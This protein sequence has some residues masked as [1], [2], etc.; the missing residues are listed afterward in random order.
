MPI[1]LSLMPLLSACGGNDAPRSELERIGEE[2]TAAQSSGTV[3]PVILAAINDPIMVDPQLAASA[4]PDAVR[5]PSEPYAAAVPH[6][7]IARGSFLN[8]TDMSGTAPAAR[9]LSDPAARQAITLAAL[10]RTLGGPRANACADRLSYSADWANR[11]PAG[12]PLHPDAR[13]VEAG[14]VEGGGCA[15]RVASVHVARPTGTLVGWYFGRARQAGYS[16]DHLI[17]G[18]THMLAGKR[19]DD[20]AAFVLFLTD[21]GDGGTDIELVS[22]R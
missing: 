6:V 3:D 10:A 8:S 13:V 20:G 21:R 18:A 4:N 15:L 2:L 1:L 5:P 19:G 9:P 7:G 16:A 17:D 14:G 11:L 22:A 12:V